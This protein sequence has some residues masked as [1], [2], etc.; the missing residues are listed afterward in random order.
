MPNAERFL[1]GVA[2]PVVAIAEAVIQ[3]IHPIPVSAESIIVEGKT[4]ELPG[5][6]QKYPLVNA[7]NGEY[8][9][10]MI[11]N[12]GLMAV[13]NEETGELIFVEKPHAIVPSE[14]A[15]DFLTD[16]Q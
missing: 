14:G 12:R 2:G 11:L 3:L 8:R 9:T 13:V 5:S 1:L 10:T 15:F 16:S 6:A 7:I 4:I